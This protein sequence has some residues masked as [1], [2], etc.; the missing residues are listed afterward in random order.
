MT[1]TTVE[2]LS[3]FDQR[4][5][6]TFYTAVQERVAAAAA[7][8][9]LDGVFTDAPD[10]VAYLCGFFFHPGE[11]P[12]AAWVDAGDARTTLLLPELEHDHALAQRASA[13]LVTYKEF[14][15]T[16][17]PFA[18]LATAMQGKRVGFGPSLTYGRWRELLDVVA[19]ALLEPCDVITRRRMVKH[20]EEI[21][22][23][24]E[25]A[26]IAGLMLASGIRFITDAFACGAPPSEADVAAHVGEVGRTIMSAEHVGIVPGPYLAS[27]LVYSGDNSSKPHALPSAHRL[28]RGDTF[29]LSLGCAVGGRYIEAER[30]FVLGSPSDEQ[31]RYFETVQHAQSVGADAIRPGRTCRESNALCLDVIRD[32]G[33]GAFIRHRQGHGI[34]VG[35]HEPPWI[36][37]GDDTEIAPGMLLSNE[38]GIYVPGHAGY[39]ISDS[40]LV[41]PAGARA[42]TH[43]PRSL[44]ECTVHV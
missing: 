43:Y 14:P 12:V 2:G 16:A 6:P 24:T 21:R 19:P 39:R 22:L 35:M 44:E 13:T 37:D 8:A 31:R 10:D 38:P 20:P 5:P 41:E 3:P 33:L 40:V 28:Q 25:A 7:A 34:G 1:T 17:S 18:P 11:R 32:A 23:H 15:G 42:L 4:L 9:G 36:E 30:T 27:G 26:R 29:M